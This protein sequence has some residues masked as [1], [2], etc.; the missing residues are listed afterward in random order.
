MYQLLLTP[1]VEDP[2]SAEVAIF[3]ARSILDVLVDEEINEI[4]APFLETLYSFIVSQD[5]ARS[6]FVLARGSCGF[7]ND[8]AKQLC[9]FQSK[10]SPIFAYLLDVFKRFSN[11]QT[12]ALNTIFEISLYCKKF[13]TE[14]DFNL[15]YSFMTANY[16]ALNLNHATKLNESVCTILSILDESKLA[17][18]IKQTMEMPGQ[19]LKTLCS[20]QGGQYRD[21]ICKAISMFSGCARAI[22]DLPD[23]AV[24]SALQPLFAEVWPNL[25]QLL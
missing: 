6:S 23:S 24:V 3:G 10:I 20:T 2:F 16:Q 12:L 19:A 5:I 11:L 17:G 18:A 7:I 15:L 21:D 1:L 4:N 22:N 8:S 13:I 14:S 25:Q 9:H